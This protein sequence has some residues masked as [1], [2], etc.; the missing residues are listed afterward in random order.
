M[1]DDYDKLQKNYKK[2]LTNIKLK[3]LQ[4]LGIEKHETWKEL[5]LIERLAGRNDQYDLFDFKVLPY[6]KGMSHDSSYSLLI[7]C[8][9]KNESTIT[10]NIT[11][12]SNFRLLE[13]PGCCGIA[14]STGAYV[15]PEF[16][17]RGI[18]TLLNMLRIEIAR[19][20]GYTVMVCTANDADDGLMDRLLLKNWWEEAFSFINKRTN[21]KVS[22][23]RVFL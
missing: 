19:A 13:F 3:L 10:T 8:R 21:N 4:I 16:R 5:K 6:V 17:E 11:T 9:T 14:L 7:E 20:H 22:M 15:F 12:V 23:Y 2:A 18:G 1:T